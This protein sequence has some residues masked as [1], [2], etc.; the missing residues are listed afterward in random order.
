MAIW[1]IALRRAAI[2]ARALWI[3][4]ECR[5]VPVPLR[6][7]PLRERD[8]AMSLETDLVGVTPAAHSEPTATDPTATTTADGC[9]NPLGWAEVLE[10]FRSQSRAW[11]VRVDGDLIFGRTIGTGRAV[12]FLNGLTGNSDLLSLLVWLLRDDFRCVVIEYPTR[13]EPS[14]NRR[15]LTAERLAADL[16]AAAEGQG[17][18]TFSLFATSFGS[19]VALEA[20]ASGRDRIDRAILQ[21]GFAH[22]NLSVFERLLYR[23]GR[24]V[25]GTLARLPFLETFQRA[26]H[27]RYFPPFDAS[28]WGFFIQNAGTTRIRDAAERAA[29]VG[30]FDCR[31]RLAE[32]RQPVLLIR[33]E[34]EGRVLAGCNDEL[35]RELAHSTTEWLHTTGPLAHLAHPHR[36]AKL[37]RTFLAEARAPGIEASSVPFNDAHGLD[38]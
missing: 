35:E 37:V 16:F 2:S 6:Q 20:L 14:S 30:T 28:R 32:I 5:T 9:P 27:Q 18:A 13:S 12:Y 7:N 36:L 25:P 17:D 26:N 33:S 24:F 31:P 1:Q 22:R 23:V 15:I 11:S 38:N 21:A 34:H 3:E 10:A 4:F 8:L 29:L 19:T